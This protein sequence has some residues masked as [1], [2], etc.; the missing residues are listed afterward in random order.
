MDPILSS[1]ELLS[2]LLG[3]ITNNMPMKALD[4]YNQV[5]SMLNANLYTILYSACSAKS[6]EKAI[7][8]G[9]QPL[10]DMPPTFED[11][12]IVMGSA[13]HMLMKFGD[14]KQAEHLFSKLNKRDASCYE[15]IMNGY[16]IYGLPEKALDLFGQASS[17][18]N[19]KLYSI[20]YSACAASF[21]EKAIKSGKR[22]LDEMPKMLNDNLIVMGSAIHNADEIWRSA[23][24]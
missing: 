11:N 2:L 14:V 10:S 3:Y 13:I 6:N 21:D 1:N 5:S 17:M 9:K 20:M 16:N 15:A 8:L 22:L 18:L 12:L 19:P 7:M 4:L 24:S 23:A